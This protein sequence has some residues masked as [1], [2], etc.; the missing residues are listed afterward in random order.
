MTDES[1]S[2][3]EP[4]LINYSCWSSHLVWLFLGSNAKLHCQFSLWHF[5]FLKHLAVSSAV[6]N[7]VPRSDLPHLLQRAP[8]FEVTS[9]NEQVGH[10][11]LHWKKLYLTMARSCMEIRSSVFSCTFFLI[12]M[13]GIWI[14]NQGKEPYLADAIKHIF[15]SFKLGVM[16]DTTKLYT[17]TLVWVDLA[18]FNVV[19]Y[20]KPEL[21][22][23]FCCR[24]AWIHQNICCSWL[25]KGDNC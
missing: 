17:P 1:N 3:K 21:V 24:V 7:A 16:I 10:S 4:L 18:F 23:S 6:P 9:D 8:S 12:Y 2:S 5:R 25:C 14:H 22:Q 20:K 19:G 15:N 13:I 11:G